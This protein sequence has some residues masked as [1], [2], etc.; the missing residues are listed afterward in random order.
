MIRKILSLLCGG[1]CFISLP[2][3]AQNPSAKLDSKPLRVYGDS[4]KFEAQITVPKHKV[5]KKEGTYVIMPELG[6]HKF[7]PIRIPS[8]ELNNAAVN[9]I[10]ITINS[11]APFD[12]DMIGN[13]LEIE[14]EY[15]YKNG[16]K[17]VE[18]RDMDDLAE[19]CIT[20]GTLFSLNG[21]YEL[22]QFDYR[23]AVQVPLKVVAQINFPLDVAKFSSTES[24]EA[25]NE[26]GRYIKKYPTSSIKIKGFASPEGTMA[27]NKELAGARAQAVKTW[28][29][30]ELDKKGYSPY[31]NADNI[32]VTSE[33]EDW[34]GFEY[35][36]TQSDLSPEKQEA[37]MDALNSDL[38]AADKEK[39]VLA[40]LG[41]AEN[42]EK[43]LMPLRRTTVVVSDKY[44]SRSGY[45]PYEIDS[46]NSKFSKGDLT[47]SAMR[48]IY[49]QEEMLQASQ[50][51]KAKAGKLTLL[52]SFYKTYPADVRAYSN[53]GALT[54]VDM[55]RFD[56]VG[57]DDALVGIGFDRD[58]VDIDE[59]VDL[60]EGKLKYKYK[61]K[62][63]DIKN[64][65]KLKFKIKEDLA[66]AEVLLMKAYHNDTENFVALNNLGAHYLTVGE[67]A[68]AK[69]YL[70]KS[71]RYQDSD[72]VNYNLGVYHARMGNYKKASEHFSK[73]SKVENI[74]YNRG[75][76]KLM[77]ND[78]KGALKDFQTFSEN[79]SEYAL[80]HYLTAV[81][82][83]RVGDI[84]AMVYGLEYAMNRNQ[85]L[86]DIASEDLEFRDYWNDKRFKD[87]ADDDFTETA[88]IEVKE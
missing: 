15:E 2:G 36:L 1:L 34:K 4:I 25:V 10:A 33:Q 88:K 58:M 53:L 6:D 19:C 30:E 60:D 20:T 11:S 67:Y 50:R 29:V 7:E 87:A 13:D 79:N 9:G 31:F 42:A 35:V 23:P 70:D 84:E 80:G 72:G 56:V 17:N 59:E 71:A 78:N 22:M 5:F 21:Q 83:A 39:A 51:T 61:Y 3:I 76:A 77:T 49:T 86:S 16:R 27:R 75:L 8:S 73:A 26:I 32:K 18:F 68:K 74:E 63:E 48:D 38:S 64:G 57:G 46:I 28:L 40:A 44:A 43:Y 82:A 66:D 81:A 69:E 55:H 65:E 24:T 52:S 12:E 85:R 54:A 47:L 14:H 41:G 62:E 37:V 45:S